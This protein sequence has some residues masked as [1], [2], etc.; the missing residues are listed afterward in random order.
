MFRRVDGQRQ[1]I[2][3][4]ACLIHFLGS[5]TVQVYEVGEEKRKKTVPPI[6]EL[7]T[8]ML[9]GSGELEERLKDP[10]VQIID[11]WGYPLQY[12]NVT[13]ARNGQIRFTPLTGEGEG[14]DPRAMDASGAKNAGS[15]DIWSQGADLDDPTD[16]ITNW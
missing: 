8:D 15:Y 9:S 16:D 7:A 4:T 5:P 14:G 12:D 3:G 6:L 13:K 2:K 10:E 11:R 1:Q